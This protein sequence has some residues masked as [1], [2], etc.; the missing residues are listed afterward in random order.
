MPVPPDLATHTVDT[1]EIAR[2]DQTI[3]WKLKGTAAKT[4]HRM[5][6]KYSD[7]SKAEWEGPEI[8]QFST[9]FIERFSIKLLDSNLKILL[10]HSKH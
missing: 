5:F 7:L 8:N 3:F 4:T 1:H 10:S 6:D 2:R 9:N